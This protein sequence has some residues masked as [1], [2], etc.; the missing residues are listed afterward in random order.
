MQK[1]LEPVQPAGVHHFRGISPR[2]TRGACGIRPQQRALGTCRLQ[3][4]GVHSYAAV[5]PTRHQCQK[6]PYL[7]RRAPAARRQRPAAS[8]RPGRRPAARRPEA[9]PRRKGLQRSPR[10]FAPALTGQRARATPRA[11]LRRSGASL[12]VAGR[13]DGVHDVA[14]RHALC[15]RV[16][17]ACQRRHDACRRARALHRKGQSPVD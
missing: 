3:A 9:R 15:V 5:G 12:V 2:P 17:R 13:A 16:V 7:T 1:L 6:A 10:V 11:P 14:A 4:T 8:L